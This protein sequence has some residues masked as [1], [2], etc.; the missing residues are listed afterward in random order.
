MITTALAVLAAISGTFAIAADRD[1]RRER[2]H[3]AF[4]VLKPLTTVLILGIALA[5]A[6]ESRAYQWGIA[7]AL[8]LSLAGDVFLMF[9]GDR[10]FLAG[11]GSFLLAHGVFAA[12]FLQGID[13]PELPGWLAAVVFYAAGFLFVLLPR[14]GKLKVPVLVYGLALAALV[15]SAAARNSA[16]GDDA[17]RCAVIGALL[18]LLS[19][20]ALGWRRFVGRYPRA[21]AVI[22]S[23][24]WASIGLI[25]WSV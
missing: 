12:A 18:F 9:E 7:V 1:D 5:A 25:A 10:F 23:T 22:L 19:D 16:I 21:Q 14:A 3:R 24:Y 6:P 8:A 20:S 4:Y 2:R 11:L 13:A 17:S 15:F